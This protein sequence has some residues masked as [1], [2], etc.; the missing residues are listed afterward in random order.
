MPRAIRTSATAFLLCLPSLA[1]AHSYSHIN[2]NDWVITCND[3][4]EV[5]ISGSESY[6]HNSVRSSCRG[7]EAAPADTVASAAGEG[8]P[9]TTTTGTAPAARADHNSVRSSKATVAPAPDAPVA[10]TVPPA[11]K[12]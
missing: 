7:H 10:P 3:G 12:P 8:G 4:T 11:G 9:A 5:N 1:F 6:V 2:G